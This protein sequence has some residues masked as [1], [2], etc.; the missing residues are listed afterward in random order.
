MKRLTLGALVGILV[1]A[2]ANA[3]SAQSV[4]TGAIAGVARDATGGVLPGVTVEAA[5]PA[6]I[7]KVRVAV[8]DDQGNYKITEL[9]PGT[10]SVTFTLPGFSS[11]RREGIE[12][13]AGFTAPVNA[14]MRV[15][16]VEETITVTG[17]APV[18]DVQSVRT[19][20]VMK[21]E[22]LD[23]LPS[24]QRDLTQLASLTLGATTTSAGRNDVGGDKGEQS[25]GVAIHGNRG[26][27]SKMTY[28]GMVMNNT[29]GA[30]GGQFRT[31][32]I[33]TVMI[34]EQV[35]DTGGNSAETET[36]GANVNMV[37]K[38][39]GNRFSVYGMANYTNKDLASG[40]V[41]DDLIARGS[42]PNQ[43]SMK[44]VWDYGIGVGGPIVRDK[45]WFYSAN[46]WWG[47]QSFAANNY[48]NKSTDFYSYVPDTA[49]PAYTDIFQRDFGGRVT[50]QAT[51]KQKLS[52]EE[53]YQASCSCWLGIA[54]TSAPEATLSFLY[55][56]HYM[57]QATWTYPRTNR[58]LLQAGASHLRQQVQFISKGAPDVPGRLSIA[59]T[60]YP[61]IGAYSWGGLPANVRF[62]NGDPQR[63]NTLSYRFAASYVTGS[64]AVKVGMQGLR[65][66]FNTRGNVPPSSVTLGFTAGVPTSLTQWAAP[67]KSD[68]R[69]RTEA[70]YGS[71]QW[72]IN[73]LTVTLGVR[74]DHVKVDALPI[75]LP[76][77]PFI[78]ARHYDALEGIPDY[79]DI[80]PRLGAAYDMFGNGKTAIRGSWG[81]YLLGLGAGP[82][83]SL[84]PANSVIASTSRPW[85]DAN[86]NFIP[87]CDL[88][89]FGT[90]GECG[91]IASAGFGSPVR[92]ATWDEE[93]RQ[94]WGVREYTNQWSVS[95]QQ[96]VR[97][98]FGVQA[99]FY[100][101]AFHNTQIAVNAA[102]TASAFDAFCLPAPADPRLGAASG[103]QVCG[104][105]NVNFASKAIPA[106]TVWYRVEDAPIPGLSGGRQEAFNGGEIS[107]NWRFRESGLI[108][109][110][111]ALGR[112]V[113]DTCFANRFPQIT[114]MMSGGTVTALGLRDDNY[115][116]D[117]GQS[118]WNGAGSQV[119]LQVVYPLPYQFMLAATYKHL[120]GIPVGGF[121]TYTNAAVAPVLG[122]NLSACAAPT[123]ACTQTATVNA[124]RPGTLYDQRLNQI[125]LR[126][127]RRL[128][129]GGARV[130]GIIELYNVLNS[131]APQAIT[132]TWGVVAAPGV[133]TP[134]ATYLRPSQF[135][136]GR[137]LKFGAQV[138][139]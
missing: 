118:L 137:L 26:D 1:V 37:P 44:Q 36:G 73:R 74:Y 131:R 116:T 48:L 120:P 2:G 85:A 10:Y 132:A 60:N 49:R 130:Q 30:S 119:K 35:V 139:F 64:H 105:T 122:R 80:S 135:L 53:H 39:G 113:T 8:T 12:L 66:M 112:A 129:L 134:G 81:R 121:V 96:E 71:D 38:D 7:E 93:A 123:G 5:S 54:A 124:V 117:D 4:S 106:R 75:D 89:N 82:L 51:T 6:L 25:T 110:G 40:K 133:A 70:I 56:P 42:R 23:A 14:D 94:G 15:G 88:T 32:K 17:A 86:R 33:N 107:L 20:R 46:R 57:T 45:V 97:P 102:L 104:N 91:P 95:V 76:A 83:V 34:A 125:D 31:Y 67:F 84:A 87:D 101:T 78:G 90:N 16:S 58:L 99:G 18:V 63:Q 24:G 72:T 47:S 55:T 127:T 11:Y 115:C 65:G 27:D 98:G 61:G 13:S 50:W 111:L 103:G 28:D 100:H 41:P 9:R 62:D 92:A 136:G 68:G 109:G 19:Q 52:F 114:G 69:L 126:G 21:A 138:D 43:N 128:N 59:D 22:V 3:V 29:G 108:S 79:H 77:G